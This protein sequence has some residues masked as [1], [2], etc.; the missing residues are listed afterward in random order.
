MAEG[1]VVTAISNGI[2]SHDSCQDT[3]GRV[4][5]VCLKFVKNFQLPPFFF[6]SSRTSAWQ[7]TLEA[8]SIAWKWWQQ[9]G[10]TLL[11]CLTES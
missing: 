10:V 3:E 6:L 11:C 8:L 5:G 1:Q 2:S 9:V 7:L 4:M